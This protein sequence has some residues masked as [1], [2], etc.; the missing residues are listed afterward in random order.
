MIFGEE[1]VGSENGSYH[2]KYISGSAHSTG[3]S[4]D[5]WVVVNSKPPE[6]DT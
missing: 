1:G 3:G 2:P 4:T 6:R 5:G